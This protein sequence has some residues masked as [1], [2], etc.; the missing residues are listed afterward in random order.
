MDAV[1]SCADH[2]K[3]RAVGAEH[4]TLASGELFGGL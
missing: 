3:A 1:G 4:A 2:P